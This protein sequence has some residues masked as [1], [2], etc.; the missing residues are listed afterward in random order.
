MWNDHH[1]VKWS[2]FYHLLYIVLSLL[3][4]LS[5]THCICIHNV[6]WR[7][8]GSV[9]IRLSL[10]TCL[11]SFNHS[12]IFSEKFDTSWILM[13]WNVEI[14]PATCKSSSGING[15][16]LTSNVSTF[17][18][19]IK[20]I[21]MHRARVVFIHKLYLQWFLKCPVHNPMLVWRTSPIYYLDVIRI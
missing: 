2:C 15:L 21:Y 12:W 13:S 5:F 7:C 3:W 11:N 6:W 4:V 8:S 19:P 16:N 9:H 18:N 17:S 20:M 14:N 10:R 1:I